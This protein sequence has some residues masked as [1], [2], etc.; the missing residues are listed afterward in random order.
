M[1]VLF[2]WD[3]KPQYE[4][5]ESGKP[6]PDLPD[7][8]DMDFRPRA[9]DELIVNHLTRKSPSLFKVRVISEY[10]ECIN[11][12]FGLDDWRVE[13]TCRVRLVEI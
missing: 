3:S 13:S 7:G 9:G 12:G 1:K 5:R 10:V 8:V 4:G 2:E 11:Y 6:L